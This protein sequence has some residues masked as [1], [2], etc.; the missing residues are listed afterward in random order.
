M[1]HEQL[2]QEILAADHAIFAAYAT[3]DIPGFGAL[4]S[5]DLEF[6][7]DTISVRKKCHNSAVINGS[8]GKRISAGSGTTVQEVNN[9]LHQHTQ[10][11][12]LFKPW[13]GA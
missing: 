9:L 10:M 3:C 2:V 7:Q 6:Y 12:K 1:P 13:A 8:R 5:N 4:L 11:S